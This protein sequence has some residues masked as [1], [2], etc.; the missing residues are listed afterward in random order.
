M[1]PQ[2]FDVPCGAVSPLCKCEDTDNDDLIPHMQ[3]R[4]H[5]QRGPDPAQV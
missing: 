4:G 3:V 5:Q 1:I 2:S